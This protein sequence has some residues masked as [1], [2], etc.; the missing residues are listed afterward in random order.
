MPNPYRISSVLKDGFEIWMRFCCQACV[1]LRAAASNAS[2]D[3][4]SARDRSPVPSGA[5]QVAMVLSIRAMWRSLE[6]FC[7]VRGYDLLAVHCCTDHLFLYSFERIECESMPVDCTL[8][9]NLSH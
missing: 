8:V 7:T 4:L 6:F 9:Y 3:N 5:V 1:V 2:A